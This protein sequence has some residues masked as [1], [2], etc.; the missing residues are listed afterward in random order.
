MACVVSIILFYSEAVESISARVDTQS[1][2]GELSQ[3]HPQEFAF[4][5]AFFHLS[6]ARLGWSLNAEGGRR[7]DRGTMTCK[8]GSEVTYKCKEVIEMAMRVDE[9]HL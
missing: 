4:G 3:H 6:Y 5:L 7:S 8:G 9:E 2:Y 1:E